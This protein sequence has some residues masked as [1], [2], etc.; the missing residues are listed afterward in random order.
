MR[1]C[2]LRFLALRAP[3]EPTQISLNRLAGLS[4]YSRGRAVLAPV[5]DS[6]SIM[7]L[8]AAIE[9]FRTHL[10]HERGLSPRTVEA[11]SSD[12]ASLS[13]FLAA[14]SSGE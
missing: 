1:G 4:L 13:A 8:D 11:Y 10:A 9:R 12:L 3:Y 14:C 5:H 6:R 2:F 7:L